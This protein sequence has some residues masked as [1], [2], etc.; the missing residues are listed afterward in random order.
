MATP[1]TSPSMAVV[2]AGP[3]TPVPFVAVVQAHV[4]FPARVVVVPLAVTR[5]IRQFAESA[6]IAAL[7]SRSATPAA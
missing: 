2:S 6:I 5:R 3:S 7:S 1:V 4:P